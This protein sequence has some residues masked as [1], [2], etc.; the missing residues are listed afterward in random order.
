MADN[1]SYGEETIH[2]FLDQIA[3]DV[4]ALPAGGSASALAGALAASMEIFVARLSLRK[5]RNPSLS[6]D[7]LKWLPHLE[8]LPKK[9]VGLMDRD[10]ESYE[11]VIQALRMPQA[12][13]EEE[14]L[15]LKSL[16]EA[17]KL[18]LVPP[19]ELVECGV[20]ML[21]CGQRLVENG[22]Q[23]ALGDAGAASELAHACLW[24]GLWICRI[25]LA[26]IGDADFV[27]RQKRL[28]EQLE[29]EGESLYRA[30]RNSLDK[31]I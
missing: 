21:R 5:R 28:L 13:S 18:A 10:A 31:R 11:R 14:T 23:V 19:L 30:V 12:T 3:R 15:R 6:E 24:G 20:D 2:E 4:P 1:S 27:K 22:D 29:E 25:N 7:L 8:E 16:Q 17:M 26:R 9:C